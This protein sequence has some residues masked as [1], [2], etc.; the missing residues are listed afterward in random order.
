MSSIL[1]E[2]PNVTHEWPFQDHL[3]S[4]NIYELDEFYL[5]G[6]LNNVHAKASP[7]SPMNNFFMTIS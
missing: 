7:V 6:D 1:K 2:I 5:L 4:K 3:W